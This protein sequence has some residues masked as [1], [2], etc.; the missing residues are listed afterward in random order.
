[1]AEEIIK[2]PENQELDKN[3]I[4][5]T[6]FPDAEDA[7]LHNVREEPFELFNFVNP[8]EPGNFRRLPVDVAEA[9]S[10]SVARLC[11]EPA[12]GR[13]KFSTDSDYI[14]LKAIE[15]SISRN[16]HLT[17]ANSCGFDLYKETD[18]GAKY[19]QVFMPPYTADGGYE[20]IA[21]FPSRKMRSFVIHFPIHCKVSDV[22]I[23]LRPDAK[24]E[25][26]H[27]YIDEAPIIVYGSS[28]VHGTACSR[29]GNCYTNILCRY[30]NRNVI[31]LGFSGNAKGEIATMEYIAKQEMSLFV[32]DYDY[33]APNADYLAETHKR[34][35]DIIRAAQPDLPII[36]ISRPNFVWRPSDSPKRRDVIVD[37]Y[38]AARAAGDKNVY[39]IDGETF[40][41]GKFENECIMDAVHPNDMGFAFMADAIECVIRRALANRTPAK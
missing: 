4:V 34:G 24:L 6:V 23:G 33:N 41:M 28:I 20:Q 40:F 32:Y 30:L 35:Y 7:V 25:G 3:M 26:G 15:P 13:V 5:E 21:R 19:I 16:S 31:N 29:P 12:G 14:L 2:A 1:M 36:M 8:K 9:T 38:R 11:Q 18:E 22:F 37:T 17:L 39:Y 10:A 27:K